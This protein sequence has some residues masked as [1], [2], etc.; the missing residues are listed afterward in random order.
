ML[1]GISV[2]VPMAHLEICIDTVREERIS[3][4]R[5]LQVRGLDSN[6]T[7]PRMNSSEGVDR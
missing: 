7:L 5:T 6:L 3:G 2:C 1:A 4:I